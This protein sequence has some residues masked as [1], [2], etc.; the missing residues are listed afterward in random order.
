MFSDNQR[1][2]LRQTYR[3][4]TFD[5]LGAATLL[6]P[7]KLAEY[8]GVDGIFSIL[9]GGAMAGIYLCL[10]GIALKRIRTDLRSF[11]KKRTPKPI[12]ILFLAYLSVYCLFVAGFCGYVF[13][14]LIQRSLI[15]ETSITVIAAVIL[16]VSAYAVSGGVE[17]R[18]RVY[19]ILFWFVMLPLALM[20]FLAARNV[21]SVYLSPLFQSSW[22]SVIKGAW[23]V[24]CGNS[25][26]FFILFFPAFL[27][28]KDKKK[29]LQTVAG[30]LFLTVGILAVLF[31]I[32][33]GIFGAR[34]L[35]ELPFPVVTM[36][37]TVQMKGS[38]FKRTDALMLG[39]WFFTLFAFEN[40]YLYYGTKMMK[41]LFCFIG[42]SC[43]FSMKQKKQNKYF[44]LAGSG[45]TFLIIML[46]EYGDGMMERFLK[47]VQ[48]IGVPLLIVIP[49]A[50]IF[51]GCQSTEL[52]DRCFPLLAATDYD[53]ESGQV[54]FFYTFPKVGL[55]SESG[56]ET[57]NI[58]IAPVY[59]KDFYE[60]RKLYDQNVT[61][62]PDVNHLK[63]FLIG[64]NMM[65]NEKQLTHM[66]ELL[67][68]EERFPR[69]TY[70]CV[71]DRPDSLLE[72]S[73]NLSEDLG[74]YLEELIEN[75]DLKENTELPTLGNLMDDKDNQ[76]KRLEFPFLTV[77]NET[78]VWKDFY[79]VDRGK[80]VGK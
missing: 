59:A 45:I 3:L 6:L 60:S 7:A 53:R 50:L 30:A 70:V 51:C 54:E 58:E 74:N 56:Q 21:D 37:S 57:A 27:A 43:K 61:K 66:L 14:K 44:L 40:L 71:T 12:R 64:K 79:V 67:Q 10:L 20:M 47:F 8:C 35:G 78:I 46:F 18:A 62:K 55:K 25:T 72:I 19:E 69:N 73:E 32:L 11:I 39:I 33:I 24:F 23:L 76:K 68:K 26:L 16:I 31:L 80:P 41:D 48:M 65:E 63:I 17:S 77:E 1:I 13:S 29:I 9:L 5:L 36:M 2:S 22:K 42:N 28:D 34:A 52:E 38:F 15:P 75:H 4:F 49:V